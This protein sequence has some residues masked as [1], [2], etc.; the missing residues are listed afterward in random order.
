MDVK[1]LHMISKQ[2][3]VICMVRSVLV[4]VHFISRSSQ[5][6]LVNNSSVLSCVIASYFLYLVAIWQDSKYPERVMLIYDG[7]HYDALAVWC[8]IL[9]FTFLLFLLS[10]CQVRGFVREEIVKYVWSIEISCPSVLCKK[11]FWLN[12]TTAT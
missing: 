10:F 7:L 3:G 4:I 6:V 1:L 5:V 12:T 2:Q 8:F 9:N 11:I